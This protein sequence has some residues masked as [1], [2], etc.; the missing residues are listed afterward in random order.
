MP[1][2]IAIF[3]LLGY[4]KNRSSCV[5]DNKDPMKFGNCKN[6]SLINAPTINHCID[7]RND[8]KINGKG[9]ISLLLIRNTCSSIQHGAAKNNTVITQH[10]YPVTYE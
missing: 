3:G 7:T 5:P 4:I 9:S 2:V 1:G 6:K 10:K 8:V